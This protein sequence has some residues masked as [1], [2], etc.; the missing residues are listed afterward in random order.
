MFV[1]GCW[2]VLVFPP[3]GDEPYM[4]LSAA[5]LARD[6]DL[7][8]APDFARGDETRVAPR[9]FREDFL[10][11]HMLPGPRGQEYN[12]HGLLLPVLFVPGYA[13]LGRVGLQ[14]LL[15]AAWAFLLARLLAALRRGGLPEA[16]AE[17]AVAILAV[18]SPLPLFAVFLGPD[19]PAALLVTLALAALLAGS[20][21]GW[22]VCLAALPWVHLKG[23]LLAGGL[24]LGGAAFR[25]RRWFRAGLAGLAAAMTGLVAVLYAFTA[26]PAW[27]PWNVLAF[28]AA[29]FNERFDL[30]QAPLSG[31]A[32]LFD[33]HQGAV[34]FPLLLLAFAGG[35][36][37][38]RSHPKLFRLAAWSAAPYLAALVCY[39]QWHGGPGAPARL[40]VVVLPLLAPLLGAGAGVLR[41]SGAGRAVLRAGFGLGV[42][43][44]WILGAV[45]ALAFVSA[46][47]RIEDALAAALGANP[48]AV[49]PDFGTDAPSAGAWILGAA[50]L[51]ALAAG[52]A[53]LLRRAARA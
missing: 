9:G 4:L 45:P 39:S 10:A 34:H 53:T 32:A 1:I 25:G 19:L 15:A 20:R 3:T 42:A 6:G 40:L 12:R 50:W 31:L 16:D 7:D 44:L 11:S 17:A 35:V 30:R 49:L 28:S 43:A 48:F 46:K 18:A 5:S 33:R 38:H 23:A 27:P 8:L 51:A 37:L 2:R 13:L 21:A 14:A 24:L 47:R 36:A 26:V 41:R 29:K 52:S 22:L